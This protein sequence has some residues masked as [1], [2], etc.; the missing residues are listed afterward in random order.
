M[1]K[2]LTLTATTALIVV[3]LFPAVYTFVAFA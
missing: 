1:A 2:M 3:A